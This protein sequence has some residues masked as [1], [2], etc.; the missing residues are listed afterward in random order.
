M[1]TRTG[2]FWGSELASA[3]D[4]QVSAGKFPLELVIGVAA[5]FLVICGVII[6]VLV[7]RRRHAESDSDTESEK[8]LDWSVDA[9]TDFASIDVTLEPDAELTTC[10][11]DVGHLATAD[12]P[13]EGIALAEEFL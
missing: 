1:F 3:R 6:V 10:T 7:Y 11:P 5:A 12:D 13:S 4:G 2:A 8:S 9:A